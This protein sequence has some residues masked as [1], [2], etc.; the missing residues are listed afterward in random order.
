[1]SGTVAQWVERLTSHRSQVRN[2]IKDTRCFP[3]QDTLHSLNLLLQLSM[4]SVTNLHYNI[5]AFFV[6]FS[7]K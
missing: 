4:W 2:H 7:P 6:G 5:D 1:M 3:K